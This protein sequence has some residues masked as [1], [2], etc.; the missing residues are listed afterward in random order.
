[1][2]I[3]HVMSF[4]IIHNKQATEGLRNLGTAKSE[5]ILQVVNICVLLVY[6]KPSSNAPTV[7]FVF[8]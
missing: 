4:L 6:Y 7:F 2:I 1:M 3:N 8:L 5:Q